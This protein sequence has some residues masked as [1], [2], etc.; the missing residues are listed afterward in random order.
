MGKVVFI[1]AALF[2]CACGTKQPTVKPITEA[3][4]A[5]ALKAIDQA[6]E[7]FDDGDCRFVDF[8]EAATKDALPKDWTRQCQQLSEILGSW[9]SFSVVH[10][11]R[12]SEPVTFVFGSA[13]LVPRN[14]PRALQNLPLKSK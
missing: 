7:R 14:S 10:Y 8:S 3:Q 13:E 4:K 5:L 1:A 2:C 11:D 12:L 9:K 6:R